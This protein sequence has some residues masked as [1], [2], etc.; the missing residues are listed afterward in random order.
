MRAVRRPDATTTASRVHHASRATPPAQSIPGHARGLYATTASSPRTSSASRGAWRS[1]SRPTAG[2]SAPTS[3]GRSP[4]PCPSPSP[5]A[6][7]RR[8]STCSCSRSRARY[9]YDADAVREA[10][11]YPDGHRRPRGHDRGDGD[12]QG[13]DGSGMDARLPTPPGATSAASGPSPPHPT[14]A[15]TSPR[16]RRSSSSRA[17]RP[18]RASAASAPTAAHRGNG[19]WRQRLVSRTT[20]Q[21]R[22]Q[23][24]M[25]AV[26]EVRLRRSDSQEAAGSTGLAPRPAGVRR[27][28]TTASPSPR[29]S[30]TRSPG[31]GTVGL[32]AQS[33]SRRALLIDLN[34]E[35]LAQCLG[36]NRQMPLGV[37]S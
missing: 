23:R 6:R 12:V 8:T 7:R 16:S 26:G 10:H 29:S 35:Y 22:L 25:P 32:V 24:P 27:A 5:T 14:P 2:T 28:T 21:R 36:R 15:R 30:W 20:D 3:S 19:W 33:L 31:T 4:T 9:F 1:R 13:R 34:P 37:G 11:K 17:S 18:G